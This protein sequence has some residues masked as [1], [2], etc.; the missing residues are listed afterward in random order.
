MEAFEGALVQ[1]RTAA[2]NTTEKAAALA[3]QNPA[4]HATLLEQRIQDRAVQT[5][6]VLIGKIDIVE[7]RDLADERSLDLVK[8]VLLAIYT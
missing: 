7:A 8:L 6:K 1:E 2:I 5:R 3:R 4:R